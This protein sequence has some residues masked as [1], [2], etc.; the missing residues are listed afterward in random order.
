MSKRIQFVLPFVQVALAVALMSHNLIGK[1]S[2]A[3]PKWRHADWQIC[4]ALNAPASVL[5]DYPA[6][7][8]YRWFGSHYPLNT[9]VEWIVRLS[10]IWSLWFCVAIELRGKGQSILAPKTRMRRA[11]DLMAIA[12]G[13]VVG[14]IGIVVGGQFGLLSLPYLIWAL[15]IVGFYGHD[16]WVS[17]GGVRQ[18]ATG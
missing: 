16:L 14:N 6:D 8:A 12:F 10:L 17:F 15:V 13:L 7:I 1:E 9:I 4:L 11:A 5:A 2:S 3:H 18:S